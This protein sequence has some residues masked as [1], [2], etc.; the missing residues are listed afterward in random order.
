[1]PAGMGALVLPISLL[2]AATMAAAQRATV[3]LDLGWR[4]ASARPNPD[5]PCPAYSI[6]VPEGWGMG[7]SGWPVTAATAAA[8]EAQACAHDAQAYSFCAKGHCGGKGTTSNE[9]GPFCIIGS[10]GRFSP[11]NAGNE[12]W[13]SQLREQSATH[14]AAAAT[15]QAARSFDDSGWAVVDLPHDASIELAPTADS[16]GP[17]GFRNATQTY[18]RKHFGLPEAWIGR[19]ITLVVDG[20]LSAS[21]WWING[22]Q[23]VNLKSDGYLPLTLRLDENPQLK[24]KFGADNVIAVWTDNSATTGWWYE[25]SGLVRNARLVATPAAAHLQAAFAVAAPAAV[26]GKIATRVTPADGLSAAA[27]VSP[28]ADVSVASSTKITVAFELYEPGRSERLAHSSVTQTVSG[29]ATLFGPE[30]SIA[31]AELWSVPRPFLYTLVTTLRVA[32]STSTN[33]PDDVDSV[34]STIGIRQLDWSPKDGL[35]VNSQPVKLRGFCNHESFAGVGAA[36]PPRVD[37]LRVQQMRGLGGNAWRTSHNPP[38]PGLLDITDRLGIAVLDENRVLATVQ[39]CQSDHKGEPSGHCNN[40]AIP[41]YFGD[42]PAETGRLALRDRLHASVAWYSL[43]N[44]GGCTDGSLLGNNT[45]KQCQTAIHAVDRSRAITGNQ[46]WDGPGAV[47][48]NTPI[49]NMYDV[50]GMSHQPTKMLD[51]WHA[52]EPDKL[53]VATECCSCE[54]QRGEDED[55][56]PTRNSS[57]IYAGN[58]AAACMARDVAKSDNV[59]WVGGTHVWT[60]HDY[61]GEPGEDNKWPHVS[62]S[63]GSYDL[64][65]LPKAMSWW[66]RSWWLGAISKADAGRPPLEAPEVVCHIVES[67]R[68]SP[69]GNR[70]INVYT[71]APF[72]RLRVNGALLQGTPVAVGKYGSAKFANVPYADGNITAEAIASV[73]G[74]TPLASHTKHSWGKEAG[75]AL[76]LDAPSLRTGTG[77]AV[78]LDGGDVALIRASVV[79]ANG[80]ICQGSTANITFAVSAGSPVRIAATGNGD[81]ADHTPA[82]ACYKA[83][84]NG[85]VRAI[86]KTTVKATASDEARALEQLVNPDAGR[87]RHSSSIAKTAVGA[88]VSFTVTASAEGLKGAS[89]TV[90]LSIDE[91]DSVL[92]VAAASVGLADIGMTH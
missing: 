69:S 54:T 36:I 19:A 75:I 24:L 3:P 60:L 74:E 9:T 16:D 11:N 26:T 42:V 50:M 31:K 44:E 28:S 46:A 90:P 38:E 68:D 72:A 2:T 82:H 81:P 35:N 83:C 51:I 78:Y 49:A 56:L 62:S 15:P 18:Y 79:D 73:G 57:Y 65:G 34:N 47:A 59:S 58:E 91:K 12:T 20:A 13:T 5:A 64:A 61:Y 7:N 14:G 66:F 88:A 76:T 86:V 40:S 89:L 48:P 4:T 41:F 27:T 33:G 6:A 22:V 45:A 23:V 53:V 84:Y 39:N 10:A 29:D 70:T 17:E 55:L 43:C 32:G 8:C 85:L 67:W 52:G 77:S 21:S 1:M 87:G 30:M 63:F 25:G 80:V 37:L 71:N 92:S